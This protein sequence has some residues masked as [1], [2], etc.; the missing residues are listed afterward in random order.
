MTG[1]RQH[2][3]RAERYPLHVPARVRPEGHATWRDADVINISRTGVLLIVASNFPVAAT[4]DLEFGLLD[5][6]ARV[7]DVHCIGQVVREER[8]VDGRSLLAAVIE[9]YDFEPAS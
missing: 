2:R 9:R 7:S 5:G 6:A 8:A 4:V 1:S 3:P